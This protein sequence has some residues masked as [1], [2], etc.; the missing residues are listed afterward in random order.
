MNLAFK[1]PQKSMGPSDKQIS[2]D[3]SNVLRL[4]DYRITMAQLVGWLMQREMDDVRN[5]VSKSLSME[6]SL[7]EEYDDPNDPGVDGGSTLIFSA[8]TDRE[9]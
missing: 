1:Q 8:P 2:V 7:K 3:V 9:E 4:N 5:M 6:K